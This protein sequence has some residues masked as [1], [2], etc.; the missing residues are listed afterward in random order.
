M[1]APS[2]QT[3]S[4][5]TSCKAGLDWNRLRILLTTRTD[6]GGPVVGRQGERGNGDCVRTATVCSTSEPPI[7]DKGYDQMKQI[8]QIVTHVRAPLTLQNRWVAQKSTGPFSAS[9]WDRKLD[10]PSRPSLCYRCD[11]TAS[12][13]TSDVLSRARYQLQDHT[14]RSDGSARLLTSL[15][16]ETYSLSIV[17][18]RD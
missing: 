2:I 5:P 17:R 4:H 1:V 12:L 6:A 15:P 9:Q 8:G 18:W 10:A 14:D 16:V 3:P 13:T 7:Q 11:A